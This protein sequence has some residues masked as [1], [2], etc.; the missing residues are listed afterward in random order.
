M[1]YLLLMIFVLLA[2]CDINPSKFGKEE[3]Q[4]FTKNI[5]YVKDNKTG[6]CFALIASRRTGVASQSGMGITTVPCDKTGL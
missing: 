5:T 3:A 4:E 1:K 2:A 6:L